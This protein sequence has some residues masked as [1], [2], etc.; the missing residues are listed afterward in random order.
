MRQ[1]EVKV[2]KG[3]RGKTRVGMKGRKSNERPRGE[4]KNLGNPK[5]ETPK[6]K[7]SVN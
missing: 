6:E 5:G 4:M 2:K 1:E 3:L 7:N